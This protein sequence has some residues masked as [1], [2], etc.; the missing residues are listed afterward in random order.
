MQEQKFKAKEKKVNRMTRSG[1][2]E[3]NLATKGSRK[4]TDKQE[5]L[6]FKKSDTE[7]SFAADR[8]ER[9]KPQKKEHTKG[10]PENKARSRLPKEKEENDSAKAEENAE[11][12][13][14]SSY[15]DDR[16]KEPRE[17]AAAVRERKAR[18]R[19]RY[20]NQKQVK[21][22]RLQ[23]DKMEADGSLNKKQKDEKI[24]GTEPKT[25]KS[26]KL[27]RAEEKSKK[28]AQK[29]EHAKKHQT[30]KKSMK[31][32]R[33]REDAPEG[34][35]YRLY[36]EET[37]KAAKT[38][39]AV[40]KAGVRLKDDVGN[41]AHNKIRQEEQDN[42][43]VQAAHKGEQAGEA[44]LRQ[45]SN[46]NFRK[47][48]KQQSSLNR[49][50]RKTYLANTNYQYRKW[51]EEHPEMQKKLFR[52]MLQKQRIKREYIIAYRAGKIQKETKRTTLKMADVST[53]VA[54]K[55]QEMITRNSTL[56]VSALLL[57]I[58]LLIIMTGISSCS[59]ILTDN[60]STV[61]ATSYIADPE[62]IEQ[63]EL[64]YTKMEAE[65]QQQI[66]QMEA[67][68][69]GK[70]EYRFNIGAIGHDPHTLISYLTAKYGDF[71]FSQV[72]R[73]LESLFS[74]QY[75]IRVEETT[76][77]R[78]E[79]RTIRVGE[80][81][82]NVVTSGY[83][84]CPICC[85]VWSGG[86]TASGAMPQANHTIA[87]DASNPFLPMGTKVVMNGVE[88]TVEDTGNFA[89][90]GVQFDVYY[91]NHAA[92]AAHGHQTWECFLAEGNANSV[93]VTRTVTADVLNVSLTAKP[94]WSVVQP[95][96]DEEQKEI[97]EVVYSCRGNLQDYDTPIE[98]NWYSYVSSY[99]G[100][101]I[102]NSTGRMELHRGVNIN[103]REGTEV[104]SV[105][106][107]TVVRTGYDSTFGN[108][109]VTQ[110]EKG[111][112]VKYAYLQ[113]VSVSRGEAVTKDTVIGTT[114]STG[115]ATG[116]QLYLEI[117]K[118]GTY[119][120]P[121]FYIGTGEGGL[122]GGGAAYDDETVRRLFAEAERYLGMPYVW[123]GSSPATSFDCSGFV[124][125]VFTNS[126]VCNMG[127]LTAQGIYNICTPIAP[128][129]ARAGDII[130]FTGT[131]NAGEPVTHVGIYA[132]NGQ[133][134]HCGDPIQYTS[135]NTAYW[136]SH[137][138]G[139]GRPN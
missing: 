85:G 78:E 38:V 53:K 139:F 55:V 47:Q 37:P 92:A 58:L 43:A 5:E 134:I 54:R 10:P 83:C 91:D 32:Q 29:L 56:I 123:G 4:L 79:T 41:L 107:G 8:E 137:F 103:V 113:N 97:Y 72:K 108:Y 67:Q 24:P 11:E 48:R 33:V 133:M 64:Y 52:K 111:V 40:K 109:V 21:A 17:S 31:L 2:V 49:L 96:M 36:F 121:I 136:Q 19:R 12:P 45:H 89:R 122:Y 25:E 15:P 69:P 84:N 20:H 94:L 106:D 16:R 66:N 100:Y 6:S 59:M 124:S 26:R 116:S 117:V 101:S 27:I 81:L 86:P 77:T 75:G 138:Y 118:D 14:E 98:L 95:R 90:Y 128:E 74:E 50:E 87:V 3:E 93:E 63:A 135:I 30:Q 46:R 73:E 42:S 88:Y 102:N 127:R 35:K 65:L 130:F 13:Q 115:S 22:S 120:N 104:Q 126:G 71:T 125:Y 9:R 129:E 105:M 57:L 28:A 112:Q 68:Y 114:G 82:G 1:L 132:G 70:D 80:S 110:D 51:L 62:E 44:L 18:N 34:S 131:Y 119:Y 99:Y 76:E 7:Q 60:V 23:F 39:P 61:I